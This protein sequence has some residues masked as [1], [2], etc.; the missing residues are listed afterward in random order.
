MDDI[1]GTLANI[2]P[3]GKNLRYLFDAKRM[4]GRFK[5]RHRSRW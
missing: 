5:I 1:I 3:N 2:E 4:N